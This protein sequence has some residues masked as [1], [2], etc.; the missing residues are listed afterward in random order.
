MAEARRLALVV[1]YN[2][3]GFAGLQRQPDQRTVLGTLAAALEGV[4][5]APVH[6]MG[7]GRTD[8][9][10][11]AQGQVVAFDATVGLPIGAFVGGLNNRL[12]A[13]VAAVYGREVAPGFDPRRDARERWYRYTMLLRSGRSPLAAAQTWLVSP[14]LNLEAMA[15]ALAALRGT[16]DFAAFAK[17]G[18]DMPPTSVRRITEARVTLAGDRLLVDIA[19][20]AFLPQQVRR[21][22]AALAL[23]G[24]GRR[25]PEWFQELVEGARPGAAGSAA[26]PQGLCLMAVRYPPPYDDLQPAQPLPVCGLPVEG[27]R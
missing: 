14:R 22:V 4:N 19:G 9:G 2:G 24:S 10:V 7:A 6:L 25:R 3:A 16:H 12:P 11:H 1:E 13:D 18:A 27:T 20:S 8:A 23:V 15:E 26:P 21:T 17:P 5:R